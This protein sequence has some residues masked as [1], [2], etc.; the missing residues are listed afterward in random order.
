MTEMRDTRTSRRRFLRDAGAATAGAA[1]ASSIAVLL[2]DGTRV[3]REVVYTTAGNYDIAKFGAVPDDATHGVAEAI[4][5]AVRDGGGVVHVPTGTWRISGPVEVPSNVTVRGAGV[6]GS[7]L[8]FDGAGGIVHA[9]GVSGATLEQFTVEGAGLSYP[10]GASY[11][12]VRRLRIRDAPGTAL[13]IEGVVDRLYVDD[14]NVE[15]AGAHGVDVATRD[16]T[17]LFV[18]A[19]SVGGFGRGGVAGEPCGL[20]LRARAHVSQVHVEPVGR[21]QVGIAFGPGSEYSTLTNWFVGLD[22]GLALRGDDRPGV[23]I[24]P[25]SAR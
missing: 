15:S 13:S 24:G 2:D 8:R 9:R 16:A 1:A 10:A 14:V 11:C 25:G 19:L 4:D 3:A 21:G 20:Q 5:A 23:Q 18:S 12:I 17:S 7:T 22:G 6:L